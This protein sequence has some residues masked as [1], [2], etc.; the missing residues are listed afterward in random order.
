[1][2]RSEARLVYSSNFFH[3]R[4]E[5]H[6]SLLCSPSETAPPLPPNSSETHEN[7]ARNWGWKLQWVSWRVTF[8]Q[9]NHA[10]WER[11]LNDDWVIPREY[12]SQISRFKLSLTKHYYKFE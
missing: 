2:D 7:S 5:P 11:F 10:V 9:L 4:K 8:L 6:R 12:E 3:I 1:M